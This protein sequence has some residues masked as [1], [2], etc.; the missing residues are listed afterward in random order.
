MVWGML[1]GALFVYSVIA[2]T[3][4]YYEGGLNLLGFLAYWDLMIA[5]ILMRFWWLRK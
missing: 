5:F 2:I 1:V 4:L 3:D